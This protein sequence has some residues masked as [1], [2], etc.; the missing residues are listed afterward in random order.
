MEDGG[1]VVIHLQRLY[2]YTISEMSEANRSDN[3]IEH[4]DNAK[5]VLDILHKSWIELAKRTR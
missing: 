4:L 5:R 3:P 1:E 2:G